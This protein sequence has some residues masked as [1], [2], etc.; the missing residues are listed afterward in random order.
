[1]KINPGAK[2]ARVFVRCDALMTSDAQSDTYPYMEIYEG[3]SAVAHEA[4]CGRISDEQLFYLRSRGL[5]EKEATAMIVR[6]F[7]EPITSKLPMDYA[8]EL[9]RLVEMEMDGA[10]G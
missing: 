10:I 4:S 9:N 1:M 3:D 6:G 8:V 5:T 2:R 7:I